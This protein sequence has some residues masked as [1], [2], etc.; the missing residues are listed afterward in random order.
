MCQLIPALM[1]EKVEMRHLK[2]CGFS[3]FSNTMLAHFI[4]FNDASVICTDGIIAYFKYD[5][6]INY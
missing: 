5:L 6:Q 3:P 2:F 1:M 4:A